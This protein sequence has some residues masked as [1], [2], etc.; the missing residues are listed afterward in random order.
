MLMPLLALLLFVFLP[1]Q[2][3]LLLYLP[4]AIGSLAIAR[5]AMRAQRG[6][7]ASGQEAMAG[8]QAVVTSVAN[9]QAEVHYKGETW[10]AVSPQPL[11]TGEKVLIEAVEGLT[12][13]V[14]PKDKSMHSENGGNQE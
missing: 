8:A 1:W 5:R 2:M 14:S 13:R 6:P 4:I 11:Q 9:G 7:P 10:R 3:A 12:L